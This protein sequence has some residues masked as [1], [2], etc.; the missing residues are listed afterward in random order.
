M[1]RRPGGRELN[2]TTIALREPQLDLAALMHGVVIVDQLNLQLLELYV[3]N[4]L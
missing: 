2:V 3:L 4:L 1:P